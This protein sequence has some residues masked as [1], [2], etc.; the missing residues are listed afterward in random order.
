[1]IHR[2]GE[3]AQL[4]SSLGDNTSLQPPLWG[5]NAGEKLQRRI[6]FCA[7]EKGSR[8]AF[9]P[10]HGK[11]KALKEESRIEC[12]WRAVPVFQQ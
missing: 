11:P 3:S 4:T 8:L 5:A 1:M 10:P 6:N 9:F 7:L 12:V 2:C